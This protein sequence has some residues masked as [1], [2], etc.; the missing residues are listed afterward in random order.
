MSKS[1]D[2]PL[3]NNPPTIEKQVEAL[4][5]QCNADPTG[6]IA[7]IRDTPLRYAH[8]KLLSA[9][10]YIGLEFPDVKMKVIFITENWEKYGWDKKKDAVYEF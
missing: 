10:K 4:M 6:S 2:D 5:E 1:A 8:P 3:K 9:L 7:M